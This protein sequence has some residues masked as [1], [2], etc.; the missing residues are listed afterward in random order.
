MFI[1]NHQNTIANTFLAEIRDTEIQTDRLRFRKN[2]ER[3]GEILAYEL[4]KS[5]HFETKEITTPL[6]KT[7]IN[8]IKTQ[9]VLICVLRAANPF[10]QGFLNIFDHSDSG[11]IGAFRTEENNDKEVSIELSYQAAPDITGKDII[12]IDPMLAT[13]K[14]FVKTV[15]ALLCNG[16]PKTIHVASVIAA[17]EGVAYINEQLDGNLKLW[18]CALDTKLNEKSYIVP[19]LG[20]AG[21]LA[22]GSKM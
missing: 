13:G 5:L 16:T 4:S 11:F 3:L 17:P 20:D 6:E 8:I 10:Y 22:F 15:K 1:L 14:S 18:T 2:L 21:D 9:P 19:G 7:G 12:I